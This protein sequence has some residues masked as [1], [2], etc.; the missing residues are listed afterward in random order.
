MHP[1]Q[2][3]NTQNPQLQHHLWIVHLLMQNHLGQSHQAQQVTCPRVV[4]INLLHLDVALVQ[5]GI[6]S[7]GGTGNLVCKQIPGHS[8]SGM[9]GLVFMLYQ[10][11]RMFSG[12]STV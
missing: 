6:D 5:P 11:C 10:V 1:W 7:H 3:L 8:T 12:E 9:H 4:L 2:E